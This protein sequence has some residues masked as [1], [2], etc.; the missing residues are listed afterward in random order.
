MQALI[1][2]QFP[3][4]FAVFPVGRLLCVKQ[5]IRTALTFS[6]KFTI[7]AVYTSDNPK[8]RKGER[9]GGRTGGEER[10]ER[11]DSIKGKTMS[12]FSSSF[13]LF[14]NELLKTYKVLHF[15]LY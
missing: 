13:L 3:V 10:E 2:P 4:G 8:G 12:M 1:T 9:E 15:F 11:K 7:K 14:A 5:G 6:A